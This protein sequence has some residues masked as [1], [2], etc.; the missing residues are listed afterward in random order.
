MKRIDVYIYEAQFDSLTSIP[1]TL[2]E[3][4]RKAIDDYIQKL[5]ALKVSASQSKTDFYGDDKYIEAERLK[6]KI[7]NTIRK[8]YIDSKR[9]E[10][11]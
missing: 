9:K 10:A 7:D 4:I 5:K 1:G 2:S 6:A 11:E 3:N 8:N